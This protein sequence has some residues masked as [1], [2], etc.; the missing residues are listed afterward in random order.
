MVLFS[1]GER[2]MSAQFVYWLLAEIDGH[3]ENFSLAN[4]PR[5]Y[6]LTPLYDVLSAYELA[7]VDNLHPQ[8]IKMAMVVKSKTRHYH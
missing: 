1:E 4:T 5:G 7:Q 6:R 8:K 3:A 2:S